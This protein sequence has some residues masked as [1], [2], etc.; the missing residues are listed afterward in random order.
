MTGAGAPG[1]PGIIKALLTDDEIDLHV[2]DMNSG[3][4]GKFL[5]KNFHLIPKA[6]D[7][8]FISFLLELCKKFKIEVLFPLVTMELFKLSKWKHQ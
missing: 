8:N 6:T 1:A 7:D 2:A 5:A 4:T 3:A